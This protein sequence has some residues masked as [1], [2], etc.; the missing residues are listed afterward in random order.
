MR[1]SV[2]RTS[3]LRPMSRPRPAARALCVA[4]ALISFAAP[5]SAQSVED[6]LARHFEAL[7][8]VEAWQSMKTTRSIG[9]LTL[10]GG[11]A[12]GEI[13][14]TAMRPAML[15]ADIVVQG[16]TVI[17][18][19]DG[20]TGWLVNP[21]AGSAT[22]QPADAATTAAMIEQADI[23]GPLI[24]WK[25]DGHTIELAGTET[26]DGV[27]AYRLEVTLRTGA[28]STYF[29]DASSYLVIRVQADRDLT[30]PTT[31]DMSDYRDVSGLMMPFAVSSTSAQGDQSVVW[32]TIEVDVDLDESSFTMPGGS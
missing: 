26:V 16:Q 10:M 20:E 27:E 2:L 25:E 23:D 1:T 8:G 19:F 18:A 31:T 22:P 24:G 5:V 12:Q 13:T 28:A 4:A 14:S 29:I 17:Q 32:Q 21:F 9:T 7:G 6:V 15:R 11:A 30:G 3:A